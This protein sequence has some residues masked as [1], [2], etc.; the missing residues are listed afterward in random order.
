MK[1]YERAIFSSVGSVHS[2]YTGSVGCTVASSF[3]GNR[4]SVCG[5]FACSPHAVQ[6]SLLY[7]LKQSKNA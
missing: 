2:V 3:G 6:A 4:I 1:T 7:F 5:E